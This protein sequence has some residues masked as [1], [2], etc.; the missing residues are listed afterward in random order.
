M[1]LLKAI[2]FDLDGTLGDTIPLCITAFKKAIEPLAGRSFSEKEITDTFGP[3]EEGTIMALIPQ[4]YEQGLR[5]YL[6]YYEALH[7]SCPRPFE[8]ITRLLST[9]KESGI[10]LSLV[11]GKGPHSTRITLQRFGM[12]DVFETIETGHIHGPRKPEGINAVLDR[13]NDI[14]TSE[15][16]YVGDAP[17]DI[18]ACRKVGIPV[19]SV[20]WASSADAERLAGMHPDAL[21]CSIDRFSEWVLASI[22]KVP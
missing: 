2:I 16:I 10:R 9:L 19:V 8:G 18:L 21:F 20:A 22:H 1:G 17:G 11:T 5:D 15:I 13:F 14:D 12:L 7:D 6:Q 3:S 4:Q